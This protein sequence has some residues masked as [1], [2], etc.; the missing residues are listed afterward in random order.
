MVLE[1]CREER[2]EEVRKA[3]SEIGLH[4]G[5]KERNGCFHDLVKLPKDKE[6]SAV[7]GKGRVKVLIGGNITLI[8]KKE[9]QISAFNFLANPVVSC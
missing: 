4:G 9:M 1:E 3:F 6:K 2:N 5:R 7:L 8:M